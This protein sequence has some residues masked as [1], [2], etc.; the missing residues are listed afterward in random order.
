MRRLAGR[1]VPIPYN[2]ALEASVVPTAE[3]IAQAARALMA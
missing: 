1:E 3:R 2:R